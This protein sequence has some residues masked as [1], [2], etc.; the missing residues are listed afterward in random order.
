VEAAIV[1]PG[2]VLVA[3][4]AAVTAAFGE[5]AFRAASCP[6]WPERTGCGRACVPAAV[7]AV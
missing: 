3:G 5:L 1:L 7:Q 4:Q 6:R 2:L